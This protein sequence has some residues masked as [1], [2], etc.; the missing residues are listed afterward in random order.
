MPTDFIEKYSIHK[1]IL[2]FTYLHK[3]LRLCVSVVEKTICPQITQKNMLF[4]N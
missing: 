2:I 4:T 1:L 3:S